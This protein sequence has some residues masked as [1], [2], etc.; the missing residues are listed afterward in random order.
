MATAIDEFMVSNKLTARANCAK[1]IAE[2]NKQLKPLKSKREKITNEIER[3][4]VFRYRIESLAESLAAAPGPENNRRAKAWTGLRNAIRET[5]NEK[6]EG[7]TLHDVEEFIMHNYPGQEIP[8]RRKL[9]LSLS[10]MGKG[11]ELS[12]IRLP[13]GTQPATYRKSE[14]VK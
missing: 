5:L 11:G 9:S 7:I 2:I 13:S 8:L 6:P 4:E 10:R 3:L 1:I 12:V 14:E